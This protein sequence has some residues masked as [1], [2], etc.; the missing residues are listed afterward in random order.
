MKRLLFTVISVAALALPSPSRADARFFY[1]K[2]LE[3]LRDCR[4]ERAQTWLPQIGDESLQ[5]DI[6]ARL[7]HQ[8]ALKNRVDA[9]YTQARESYA[10]CD[11]ADAAEKL[12]RAIYAPGCQRIRQQLSNKLKTILAAAHDDARI[13]QQ[14][15]AISSDIRHTDNADISDSDSVNLLGDRLK[16]LSGLV[17]KAACASLNDKIS[18]FVSVEQKRYTRLEFANRPYAAVRHSLDKCD[19]PQSLSLIQ[20]LPD[21]ERKEQFRA[22]VASLQTLE[23]ETGETLERVADDYAQCRFASA[24]Q[25]LDQLR[26]KQRCEKAIAD[27]DIRVARARADYQQD[28]R[29]IKLLENA[30]KASSAQQA[31]ASLAKASQLN[32][33]QPQQVGLDKLVAQK[34]QQL[35]PSQQVAAKD[36]S[37]WTHGEAY[38][39]ESAQR[40]GCRCAA[41]YEPNDLKT[42]CVP[43]PATQVAKLDCSRWENAEP[44]WFSQAREAG[45]FCKKGFRWKLDYTACEPVPSG[46]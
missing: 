16:A 40:P 7:T 46:R 27:L 45:C 37:A 21:G 10:R 14:W 34:R 25:T 36:C 35:P 22:E 17:G 23:K 28:Q 3:A 18:R 44:R 41:G 9:L 6:Q 8:R 43:T 26:K 11:Y 42:G 1:N 5:Q 29:V 39:V 38:W 30:K 32:V 31:Y 2:A 20:A 15:L 33:C 4:I 24:L 19:I 12:E 13:E